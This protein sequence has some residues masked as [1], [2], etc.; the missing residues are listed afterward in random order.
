M[1]RREVAV[2][3]LR[4]RSLVFAAA[5]AAGLALGGPAIA[6]EKLTVWW[7]KGFYKSEDDALLQAVKKFEQKTGVTVDLS[8]YPVQDMI[9]KTVSALDAGTP[10]DVGFADVY[11]FQVTGKWAFDGK[12]ED[13]SDV[14]EP[15]KA[16]FAPNTVETTYLFND[17]AKKRAY[18]AF[19]LK[20]Q[21]MHIEYWKDMLAEAGDSNVPD[22]W[23]EY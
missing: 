7:A 14:L 15:I 6:Q 8:Q 20:Q 4:W 17:K 18:Y 9:P 2:T 23:K 1:G 5:A 3:T 10:P 22:T 21:T 19:P 13:I 11:D 16:N 12:L